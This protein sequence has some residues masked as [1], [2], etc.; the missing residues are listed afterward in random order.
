[1][2]LQRLGI[3]RQ[4]RRS[5]ALAFQAS[6]TRLRFQRACPQHAVAWDEKKVYPL[7]CLV[8]RNRGP[9]GRHSRLKKTSGLNPIAL[10]MRTF[11]QGSWAPIQSIRRSLEYMTKSKKALIAG[12]ALAGLLAG[13][14]A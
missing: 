10:G 12:A 1:M 14:G 6:D 11:P 7:A 4:G 3:P 13:S 8:G 2:P 9:R 5:L